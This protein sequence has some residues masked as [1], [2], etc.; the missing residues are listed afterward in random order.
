MMRQTARFYSVVA[1]LAACSN[2]APSWP[3]LIES[4]IVSHYPK[5]E[6]TPA[7]DGLNVRLAGR[8]HRVELAPII[9]QCNRGPSDCE[10][11]M[12]EMLLELGKEPH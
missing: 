7:A 3:R 8:S 5:A 10:R 4:R 11:V 1:F 9:L 6:V 12:T 2:E